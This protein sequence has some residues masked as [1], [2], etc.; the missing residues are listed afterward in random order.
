MLR[1]LRVGLVDIDVERAARLAGFAAELGG[2]VTGRFLLDGPRNLPRLTGSMAWDRPAWGAARADRLDLEVTTERGVLQAGVHLRVA[3]QEV[4][5]A[6]AGLPHDRDALHP[7][8]LLLQTATRL[9]ATARDLDLA[10]LTPLLP[11]AVRNPQGIARLDARIRGGAPVPEVHGEIEVTG[12]SIG[13]PAL[14]QTLSPVTATVR[15]DPKAI[16]LER[17]RAGEGDTDATLSG[18]VGLLAGRP[19]SADLKAR[20]RQFKLGDSRR[21]SASVS[22]EIALRGPVEGLVARG[23]LEFSGA[24]LSLPEPEDR[25]MREIRVLGLPGERGGPLVEQTRAGPGAWERTTLDLGLKVPRNTWLEG[26]GL[27]LE[28]GGDLQ[29]TKDPL[30]PPHYTGSLKTVRGAYRLQGKSFDIR[31]GVVT[32]TGATAFDPRIQVVAEHRV[33]D[34]TILA[35]L[36]GL[37]SDPRITLSSEPPLDKTDILSYLVFGRP[38]S[39]LA[40]QQS[41]ELGETATNLAA[42]MAAGEISQALRGV[43]PVDTLEI[44]MGESG[45]YPALGV[46]K[47]VHEDVYI[48]YGQTPG[49]EEGADIQVE[50]RLTPSWSV[51]SGAKQTGEAGADVIWSREY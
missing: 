33:G 11:R 1:D 31:S 22:G 45:S 3:G 34:V 44:G 32:L 18:T 16:H 48:R 36:S 2:K 20:F 51:E 26:R 4:L 27:T 46:G 25:L 15:L 30:G 14:G 6:Q 8:R 37:A 7:E 40:N 39:E 35:E 28:V 43:L 49:V 9:D 42:T 23:E 47:Y 13:I 17:I 21:L 10:W 19:A 5:S 12:G 50:W 24:R 38:S 41:I 29:L